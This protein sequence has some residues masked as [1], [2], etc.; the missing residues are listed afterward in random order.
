LI[1]IN[2][3]IVDLLLTTSQF[4]SN[5]FTKSGINNE[6]LLKIELKNEEFVCKNLKTKPDIVFHS[7][8]IILLSL[9]IL[10]IFCLV[11]VTC[12]INDKK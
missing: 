11:V 2:R 5:D 7:L 3:N 12:A 6:N 8:F 10:S 4:L 1:D 9:L